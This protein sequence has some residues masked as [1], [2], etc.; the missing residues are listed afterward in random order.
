MSIFSMVDSFHDPENI[1]RKYGD[2][3][4]YSCNQKRLSISLKLIS[5]LPLFISFITY[6]IANLTLCSFHSR[7]KAFNVTSESLPSRKSVSN[8]YLDV[9]LSLRRLGVC[10]I[11]SNSS[12]TMSS[13]STS[14]TT[15][16][17]LCLLCTTS[18]IKSVEI[19]D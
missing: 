14:S 10:I 9:V 19:L 11:S 2:C 8:I 3:C 7:L 16:P 5:L 12:S 1:E 6:S 15:L 13:I 4:R 18:M 17:F